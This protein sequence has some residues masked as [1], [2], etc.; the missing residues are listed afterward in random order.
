MKK[1][2]HPAILFSA[3]LI[4]YFIGRAIGGIAG[5][6][7]CLIGTIMFLSGFVSLIMMFF[8]GSSNKNKLSDTLDKIYGSNLSHDKKVELSLKAVEKAQLN[9]EETYVFIE[10]LENAYNIQVQ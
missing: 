4:T 5:G 7:V 2:I 6:A 10:N 9:Q 1:N 3:G 8:A